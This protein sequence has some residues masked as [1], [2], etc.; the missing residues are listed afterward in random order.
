MKL[1]AA[2]LLCGAAFAQG[3][4][5]TGEDLAWKVET[6]QFV[7]DL[8]RN[9]GTGRNGQI[10]TIFV[11]DPGVLLTRARPTST[12]HLSPNAA[13]AQ[14]WAG[15]NRWDPPKRFAAKRG[16]GTFRVER[17]GEMPNVPQLW[18]KTAYEFTADSPSIA[19]EESIEATADAPVALLRLCEWSCGPGADNPFSHIGWEDAQAKVTV[20]RKEGEQ[21]LPF[22]T[23]WMGFY[24]EAKRF[25]FAAVIDR[26]EAS[27]L[28]GESAR[29]GGDPHYFY[30]ILV[31]SEAGKLVTVPRGSRYAIRY[32]V[33]CFRP[34]DTAHPFAEL[35][36]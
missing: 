33:M 3:V 31:G 8:S 14:H 36:P 21:T 29:F 25:T 7:V 19:V 34:R 11:K 17:E 32:R 6:A 9:P 22:S 13:A 24:S 16:R 30:R 26:V 27:F 10:N 1:L 23:R 5:V 15:I 20:R 2:I 18:V 12:L 28:T 35:K 4:R